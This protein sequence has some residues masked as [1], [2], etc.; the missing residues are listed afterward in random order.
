[1]WIAIKL[2]AYLLCGSSSILMLYGLYGLVTSADKNGNLKFN[3]KTAWLIGC[4]LSLFFGIMLLAFANH[5]HQKQQS[6]KVTVVQKCGQ[7]MGYYP[8]TDKQVLVRETVRFGRTGSHEIRYAMTL[9]IDGK[10]DYFLPLPD[11]FQKIPIGSW[12]CFDI[13]DGS[14]TQG[15]YQNQ[16]LRTVS[17]IDNK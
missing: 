11:N 3:S 16:I 17:V 5:M 4:I 13:Q 9:K 8:K 7:V 12:A 14:K 2:F 15:A 10:Q 1:M 6:L